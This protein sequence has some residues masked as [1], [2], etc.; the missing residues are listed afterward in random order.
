MRRVASLSQEVLRVSDPGKKDI[1]RPGEASPSSF[2]REQES[3]PEAPTSELAS[4]VGKKGPSDL[5]TMS[6][7]FP[8]AGLKPPQPLGLPFCQS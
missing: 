4:L 5:T 8:E 7:G 6:L 2:P 1:N 3:K